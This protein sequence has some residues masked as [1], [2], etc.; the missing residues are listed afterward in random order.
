MDS[1][2]ATTP[3][4][5]GR[6]FLFVTAA[7]AIKQMSYIIVNGSI[8]NWI[9]DGFKRGMRDNVP[10]SETLH[11]LFTCTLCMTTQLSLW[12]VTLPTLVVLFVGVVDL[13]FLPAE[14]IARFLYTVGFGLMLGF[15]VGG[16]ATIFMTRTEYP[17]T[18]YQRLY[19]DHTRL[20]SDYNLL[21][22][23]LDLL[24]ESYDLLRS[25]R[26]SSVSSSINL[27]VS[28]EDMTA[29]FDKID[30]SCKGIQCLIRR[31]Y[32]F[33]DTA[34]DVCAE[35]VKEKQLTASQHK[36]LKGKLMPI[37]ELY[38]SHQWEIANDPVRRAAA[39]ER[40]YQ[41]LNVQPAAVS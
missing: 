7:F 15:G 21:E 9:R 39:I 30:R 26:D 11:A 5:L 13:Q 34:A 40:F 37:V 31:S 19:R 18:K 4:L 25:Q 33:D 32:C 41:T 28:L 38:F 17:P 10:G 3:V 12:L 35:W 23:D 20:Q 29:L 36:L 1:F 27:P 2:L 14:G 22:A 8:F 24:Q 16:L 6:A